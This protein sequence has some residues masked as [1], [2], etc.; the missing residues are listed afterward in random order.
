MKVIGLSLQIGSRQL[1][2]NLSFSVGTG[3]FW[4]DGPSGCGKSTLMNSLR[5]MRKPDKGDVF[6][7]G[8]NLYSLPEKDKEALLTSQVSY[9]GQEPSLLGDFSLEDN[10]KAVLSPE[11]LV[12]SKH[13]IDAFCFG[14][15]VQKKIRYLSGGE[16][17][18]AELILALSKEASLYCFD[19]PFA[20]LDKASKEMLVTY[21]NT[22]SQQ[23]TV[24]LINH[25]V[26][27]QGLQI[28]GK[29]IFSPDGIQLESM[30]SP[31]PNCPPEPLPKPKK[32]L[33]RL[34]LKSLLNYDKAMSF[35]KI[36]LSFG[37][38]CLFCLGMGFTNTK[39]KF[40][41][42]LISAAADPFAYIGCFYQGTDTTPSDTYSLE[43]KNNGFELYSLGG[44]G[45][46]IYLTNNLSED[47][48]LCFTN[49]SQFYQ[50]PELLIGEKSI[51]VVYLTENEVTGPVSQCQ[52]VR[53][54]L[55]DYQ[56]GTLFETSE[57]LLEEMMRAD[58]FAGVKNDQ[59][60]SLFDLLSFLYFNG[61]EFSFSSLDGKASPVPI[62][63]SQSQ[64]D[65]C[66]SKLFPAGGKAA[67]TTFG[68]TDYWISFVPET[69][70]DLSLV[71]SVKA[72]KDILQKN[73]PSYFFFY[74]DK[75]T[76]SSLSPSFHTADTI[77]NETDQR[78]VFLSYWI[79]FSCLLVL[80]VFFVILTIRGKK[81]ENRSLRL[82]LMNQGRSLRR[83]RLVVL[84]HSVILYLPSLIFGFLFYPLLA[85]PY[86]NDA[87]MKLSYQ[88][89]EGFYYYSQEPKNPYYDGIFSPVQ[90]F[91]FEG[92]FFL[93]LFVFL[94]LVSLETWETER[95]SFS[96]QKK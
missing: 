51:P 59:G 57:S 63:I 29:M 49:D 13:W 83:F 62:T 64:E 79:G 41:I 50:T 15:F 23:K 74:F 80:E 10:L 69:G 36:V 53:L 81:K 58:V 17:Q 65:S 4:I 3:L 85:I 95:T 19:E 40:Q 45:S 9:A 20:S 94:L 34:G 93:I 44:I 37:L 54:L 28:T 16:R 26:A 31:E 48:V 71:L 86:A 72:Y 75:K 89:V 6:L 8:K 35:F 12:Q 52:K 21:L 5:G 43:K 87:A 39:S 47:K 32:G 67:L 25:D 1:V 24:L 11:E 92:L 30:D 82:A 76:L 14:E 56:K 27:L 2:S 73:S 70:S 7:N 33:S 42:D 88:P 90:Q 84:I 46:N 60:K 68:Q 66:T 55:D 77:K 91:T 61:T 18:K 38:V 22:L 96:Q 78:A